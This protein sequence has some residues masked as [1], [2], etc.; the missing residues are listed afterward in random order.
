MRF[1]DWTGNTVLRSGAAV[2]LLST[3]SSIS[4][5]DILF[6]KV[7]VKIFKVVS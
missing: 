5:L 3:V 6:V 7:K 4:R 2:P 1:H